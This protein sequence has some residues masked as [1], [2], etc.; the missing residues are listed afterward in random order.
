MYIKGW[1]VL[2]F[3][4]FLTWL[5]DLTPN[6]HSQFCPPPPNAI[7][8]A[9]P[10]GFSIFYFSHVPCRN[11][12]MGT[13]FCLSFNSLNIVRYGSETCSS[14]RTILMLLSIKRAEWC[15]FILG[16]TLRICETAKYEPAKSEGR[17][18]KYIANKTFG[19]LYFNALCRGIARTPLPPAMAMAINVVMLSLFT[20]WR[21]NVGE[22]V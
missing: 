21:H 12:V 9:T 15:I 16:A 14:C 1:F 19:A 5:L 6:T 22:E 2:I 17:L 10:M 8:Q 20:P 4:L 11:I 18:Y 7:N 3:H 13:C